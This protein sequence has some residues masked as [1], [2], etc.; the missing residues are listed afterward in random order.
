[1]GAA[2]PG[3]SARR[4]W[5]QFLASLVLGLMFTGVAAL[6]LATLDPVRACALLS[7]VFAFA[8][9]ASFSGRTSGTSRTFLSLFLFALYVSVNVSRGAWA[10]VVGLHGNATAVSI[11]GWTGFGMLA[12]LGGHG[13]NRRTAGI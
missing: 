1:M 9:F 13:W 8:A 4:Y 6:R 2:V 12:L 5:R 3:G 10:D 7:G 11:L